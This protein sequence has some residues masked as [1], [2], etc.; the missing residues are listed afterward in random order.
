M[1]DPVVLQVRDEIAISPDGTSFTSSCETHTGGS[2]R[3][4][5]HNLRTYI[6][7][8]WHGDGTRMSPT[9]GKEDLH[10][11][12]I[13]KRVWDAT[14]QPI[15]HR[16]VPCHEGPLCGVVHLQGVRVRLPLQEACTPQ[17]VHLI[18]VP[19][20]RP[21][22][23]P[24][25]IYYSHQPFDEPSIAWRVY[26]NLK[27]PASGA[28]IWSKLVSDLPAAGAENFHAK[29]G[30][31]DLMIERRDSLVVYLESWTP[32]LRSVFEVLPELG[33]LNCDT[34][35]ITLRI[36]T[37]VSLGQEPKLSPKFR[38]MS[39]GQH[40]SHVL[41][42]ALVHSQGLPE[43]MAQAS[44]SETLQSSGI[45]PRMIYLNAEESF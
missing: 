32:E 40:R 30:A 16:E 4:L 39:F 25:F 24:G 20:L 38:G 15:A 6:Y 11:E 34:S 37:G 27:D 42:E 41:A 21:Y 45:N 13:Y 2:E 12:G 14:D 29:I 43:A 10:D 35:A 7:R 5:K 33:A 19:K 8:R 31:T 3:E 44:I 17:G 26:I 18:G 1:L 28:G 36:T 9:A 23:S 22:I